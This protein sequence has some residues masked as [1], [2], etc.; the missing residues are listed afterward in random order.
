MKRKRGSRISPEHEAELVRLAQGPDPEAARRAAAELI[1]AHT[2]FIV[3]VIKEFTIP[4]WVSEE[5][6]M[7]QGRLGILDA[8][9]RFEPAKGYRLLTYA[10]WR[11]KKEI[12]SYMS[13]MG[14]PAKVPFPDVVKL[15]RI[16]NKLQSDPDSMSE[17]EHAQLKLQKNLH[18]LELI[19]GCLPIHPTEHGASR[20]SDNFVAGIESQLMS[21]DA[22][23]VV[24]EQIMLEE[25]ASKIGELP[26]LEGVLLGCYYGMYAARA[27]MTTRELAGE[28]SKLQGT[29]DSWDVTPGTGGFGLEIGA[30]YNG[31][32]KVIKQAEGKLRGILRKSFDSLADDCLET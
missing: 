6:V 13:E 22:A 31:I 17:E 30:T 4:S 5:D 10:Y 3:T 18:I 14:Y 24:I 19:F 29:E 28:V 7:Q 9:R 12:T 32:G 21:P 11:I 26:A 15:K 1:E 2:P 16:L 20:E 23:D 25:L 8:I 27:P